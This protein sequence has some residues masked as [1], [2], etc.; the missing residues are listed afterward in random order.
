MGFRRG[1]FPRIEESSK[2][3]ARRALAGRSR[4]RSGSRGSAPEL[5]SEER[6]GEER[7]SV[8]AP[9]P[10]RAPRERSEGSSSSLLGGER[11]E[12][13]ESAILGRA[14]RAGGEEV[15]RALIEPS[16]AVFAMGVSRTLTVVD[17]EKRKTRTG[18]AVGPSRAPSHRGR[19][20][21]ANHRSNA[22][23]L[24]AD[25]LDELSARKARTRPPFREFLEERAPGSRATARALELGEWRPAA[26]RA[27]RGSAAR[28]R[29]SLW[30][31]HPP[32]SPLPLGAR[33]TLSSATRPSRGCSPL[34]PT[35]EAPRDE[36]S[37]WGEAEEGE[38]EEE[39]EEEEGPG[40]E[41]REI[42]I[43]E[44]ITGS[45]LLLEIARRVSGKPRAQPPEHPRGIPDASPTPP[46]PARPCRGTFLG[47]SRRLSKRD[48][49]ARSPRGP[50]LA[51]GAARKRAARWES[52][53]RPERDASRVSTGHSRF[54]VKPQL[55]ATSNYA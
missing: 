14:I 18:A 47:G 44:R 11:A 16:A 51:G 49:E 25:P 4:D 31:A 2:Y 27:G 1:A 38:E 50:R 41:R 33:S 24:S 26:R 40:R 29:Q 17:G 28:P 10:P 42:K 19:V 21:R 23:D 20:G 55:G 9:W 8:E 3:L 30:S 48:R 36:R 15:D 46:T 39:E 34:A 35:K 54:D 7:R 6:R 52:A 32:F 45:D 12:F 13:R 22:L 5:G 37:A 43:H 53:E